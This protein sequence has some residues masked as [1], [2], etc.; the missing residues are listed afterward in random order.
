MPALNIQTLKLNTKA[1]ET[2]QGS[3]AGAKLSET[4][5]SSFRSMLD[6]MNQA[7]AT[8]GSS[9]KTE[10]AKTKKL[11]S[12]IKGEDKA[13]SRKNTVKDN[14]ANENNQTEEAFAIGNLVV[15]DDEAV[16]QEALV[17]NLNVVPLQDDEMI[18][19]EEALD[20]E[21]EVKVEDPALDSLKLS[22]SRMDSYFASGEVKDLNAEASSP[23]EEGDEAPET[24][25]FTGLQDAELASSAQNAVE[26]PSQEVV[27]NARA[28]EDKTESTEDNQVLPDTQNTNIADIAQN[29]SSETKV[30]L[31]T[32]KAQDE[33]KEVKKSLFTVTDLRTEKVAEVQDKKI[34][35]SAEV[36][37]NTE[38]NAQEE[39]GNTLDMTLTLTND[40]NSDIASLSDQ[41]AAANGSTFQEML[42]Q[43]VQQNA[44]E[45]VKAGNIVLKDNNTGTINMQLKP[46]S[47]GNVKI[48]L[49][50]ND[51]VISG[52]ITVASKEAFEA[53][54][55]NLDTIKQAFVQNGFENATL[56]LN[57]AEN[58]NNG[59]LNHNQQNAGNAEY[60]SRRTY[61]GFVADEDEGSSVEQT[62]SAYGRSSS[63]IIDVVA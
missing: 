56:N 53:F 2:Q 20:G 43:Q 21:A 35:E 31:K 1:S 27:E 13:S 29:E 6:G 3:T 22:Q 15:E 44:P 48:S 51:K 46:E 37:V 28:A 58:N 26:V 14:S 12:K 4:R 50:L 7:K 40:A 49:S 41:S 62:A 25:E 52:Q 47:L 59:F 38:H 55:Q 24:V 63:H 30:P 36:K 17:Q 11:A 57:L 33:K 9:R 23:I 60:N 34:E 5:T 39:K 42:N 19:V 32:V 10:D 45:F 8:D 54:K 18:E 16:N 61:S